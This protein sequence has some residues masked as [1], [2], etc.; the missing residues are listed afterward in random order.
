MSMSTHSTA[1]WH[2]HSAYVLRE[3]TAEWTE[4]LVPWRRVAREMQRTLHDCGTKKS[5]IE[6]DPYERSTSVESSHFSI[7]QVEGEQA[8][9][10][11]A[12]T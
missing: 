4:E 5:D 6:Q 7:I 9:Q 3:S 1:L 2:S 8:Q 12:I 10:G 11:E